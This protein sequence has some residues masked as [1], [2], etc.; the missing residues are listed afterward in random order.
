MDRR[1]HSLFPFHVSRRPLIA[2]VVAVGLLASACGE[3]D[4][5]AAGTTTTPE[6]PVD[7][8]AADNSAADNTAADPTT[9][10]TD[11]APAANDPSTFFPD[12]LDATATQADDGTW[13]FNVTLSSPYDTPEQY[14]DAWR[15]VDADGNELGI[16]ILGHDH[17]T[18]QPFTRSHS[19]IVIPD[20]IT[21]VT[22]EG[23]DQANGWGGDFLEFELPA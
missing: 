6:T 16:R 20:G 7:S 9:T 19:G 2:G 14:A 18:E 3:S 21:T 22:I 23:R 12:V 8:S 10:L 1:H 17:A 13:T 11:A 15:V 4:E 5:D